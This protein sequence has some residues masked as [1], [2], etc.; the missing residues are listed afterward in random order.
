MRVHG[1]TSE[2]PVDRFERDKRNAPRPLAAGSYR[3]PGAVPANAP[4][5]R[6]RAVV[7]VEKR[8][9]RVYAGAAR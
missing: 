6:P 3:R 8:S 9:L 2:R 1:T 4:A 7:V 5:Q